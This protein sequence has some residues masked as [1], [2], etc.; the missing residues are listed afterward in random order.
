MLKP[1][2]KMKKYLILSIL[3][4]TSA[5]LFSHPVLAKEPEVSV[6]EK[7]MNVQFD[8]PASDWDVG[9]PDAGDYFGIFSRMEV[10]L[11]ARSKNSCNIDSWMTIEKEKK[12]S[13]AAYSRSEGDLYKDQGVADYEMKYEYW[14][15]DVAARV[16]GA[17]T[18][19]GPASKIGAMQSRITAGDGE[20]IYQNTVY[21]IV[22]ER[23]LLTIMFSA[24]QTSWADK[25][26]LVIVDKVINSFKINGDPDPREA[27]IGDHFRALPHPG[28]SLDN[29][30]NRMPMKQQQEEEETP[31][32]PSSEVESSM[33]TIMTELNKIIDKT[34]DSDNFDTLKSSYKKI[35][36]EIAEY[37][38]VDS[39]DLDSVSAPKSIESVTIVRNGTELTIK[40]DAGGKAPPFNKIL[41]QDDKIC[42]VIPFKPNKDSNIHV[43][44]TVTDVSSTLL[45]A[46]IESA[47]S[48]DKGRDI[49]EDTKTLNSQFP[50]TTFPREYKG[51]DPISLDLNCE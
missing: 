20:T 46:Q 32:K 39:I 12:G 41:K 8:Y 25:K 11:F 1:N 34:R 19:A 23:S 26:C 18:A 5:F 22:N 43:T 37:M 10:N 29:S 6:I 42:F 16:V 48:D 49:T 28:G 17:V 21:S 7:L 31:G 24:P 3:L 44:G 15:G 2:H 9:K 51:D 13:V 45:V 14:P 47:Y 40:K 33:H 50:E 36:K 30:P 4:T 38:D 27:D 35:L